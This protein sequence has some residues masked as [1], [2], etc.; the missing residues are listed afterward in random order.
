MML[1]LPI[2][3][4]SALSYHRL[5]PDLALQFRT[6]NRKTQKQNKAGHKIRLD[7]NFLFAFVKQ[8]FSGK[9]NSKNVGLM[10]LQWTEVSITLGHPKA[11]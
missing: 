8:G 4:S 6:S 11:N 2:I 5:L 10:V 3:K 7:T 9:R 1:S